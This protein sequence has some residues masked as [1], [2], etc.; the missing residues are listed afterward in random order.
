MY[1]IEQIEKYSPIMWT[2]KP[3]RVG[4]SVIRVRANTIHLTG[5]SILIDPSGSS[6][7]RTVLAVDNH[8]ITLSAPLIYDHDTNTPIKRLKITGGE[9]MVFTPEMFGAVGDGTTDDTNALN[10]AVQA[11]GESGGGIVRLTQAYNYDIGGETVFACYDEMYYGIL[12]NYDNVFIKGPGKL[13]L[14]HVPDYNLTTGHF[15]SVLFTRQPQ[16]V[17]FPQ[18]GGTWIDNVGIEGIYFDNRLTFDQRASM[19]TGNGHTSCVNFAHAR[20][21]FCRNVTVMKAFNAGLYAVLASSDGA[22]KNNTIIGSSGQGFFLDGIQ[23]VEVTGNRVYGRHGAF[24]DD[25][26]RINSEGIAVV[27]NTD[28]LTNAK[29]NIIGHN[30]IPVTSGPAISLMGS[31]NLIT[32]NISGNK[33]MVNCARNM[34]GTFNA[35]NT[36]IVNN[37]I[38]SVGGAPDHAGILVYG[39]TAH[40][41]DG[42]PLPQRNIVVA[43]NRINKYASSVG[44]GRPIEFGEQVENSYAVNN[45]INGATVTEDVSCSGNTITPN[46]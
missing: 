27:A 44:W 38:I 35:E 12:V 6:E 19:A 37:R 30:H 1:S 26:Y 45:Y 29:W 17:V 41:H 36:M 31:D 13:I 3:S 28:N 15:I 16:T 25:E 18:L 4:D 23:Q 2:E 33:I 43:N 14:D 22:F 40:P 46:Y 5:E 11:C 24:T 10:R 8:E 32:G 21:F 20:N 7:S 42:Q 34:N 9:Y 39:F